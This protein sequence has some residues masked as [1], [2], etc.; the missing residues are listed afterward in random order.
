MIR[1]TVRHGIFLL[2]LA[3]ALL[4][5]AGCRRSPL[6]TA[7]FAPANPTVG[8]TR[9]SISGTASA[10]KIVTDISTYPDGSMHRFVFKASAS[11][12][13]VD[14]P[15]LLKQLGTY[16]DFLRDES[17]GAS[18]KLTYVGYGDF[19]VG[20]D[21]VSETVKRVNQQVSF[22]V[23][24][25]GLNGFSG[26][27]VPTIPDLA[28]IPGAATSWFPPVV[29]VSS[30]APTETTLSIITLLSTPPGTYTVHVQ[31]SSGSVARTAP[32]PMTIDVPKPD[33]NSLTASFSPANATVGVT[34]VQITG[35]AT[36]GQ[37]LRDASIFPDGITHT[38]FFRASGDGKYL[39]GPFLLR[40]LGIY[41]DVI[42]DSATGAKTTVAYQGRGDFKL[43]VSDPNRTV[44]RGQHAKIKVTVTSLS[45]LNGRVTPTVCE[46]GDHEGVSTLWSEA[47]VPVHSNQSTSVALDLGTSSATRP[48]T[49]KIEVQ[50]TSGSVTH[51]APSAI[52][53]TVK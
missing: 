9:V 20:V 10:G 13:Y 32:T 44:T 6:I 46:R 3:S 7:A 34:N 48:G 15:F 24:F 16:H 37:M 53:L 35:R 40:E 39:D 45:N 47:S 21:H 11:G 50:G 49:Y 2:V 27:V 23:S 41:H 19:T 33:P 26:I 18:T 51:M 25:K 42:L 17:T 38:F 8:L 43:S 28:R 12:T 14:G 29:S 36:P 52:S 1:M 22:R 31:G 30:I 4:P 5:V